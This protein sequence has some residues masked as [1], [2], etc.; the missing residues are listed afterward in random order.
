MSFEYKNRKLL[1]FSLLDITERKKAEE[2]LKESEAYNKVL[3]QDSKIPLIIMAPETAEFIDC[4]DAAV[5]IYGCKNREE[6]IGKTPVHFS[7]KMQDDGQTTEIKAKNNIKMAMEN[8]FVNFE[9]KHYR[10][11]GET[12]DAE[13]QLMRFAYKNQTLLQCS[14][15]DI[16]ERKKAENELKHLRNY[17][18]NIINSMPSVL[19]GI[20]PS[21]MVTQWNL[22]AEKKTGI[23]SAKAVG[24][25][26]DEV[27]PQMQGEM[28]RVLDAIRTREMKIDPKI[29]RKENGE[30]VYEDITIFP[31]I[32]NGIEGAVIRVDDVSERVRLEEMMI[33]SEK[34]MSVGGLAAGMAH[35]INNPLAGILQNLQVIK[36][37]LSA[38]L[39][40]N[41]EIAEKLKISIDT[42]IQY[43]EER[44]ILKMLESVTESGRRAAKIVENMLRFSRKSEA[45][46]NPQKIDILLDETIELARNDYDLK[47]KF[48]FRQIEIKKEIEANLP[49]VECEAS[50]I[51]QVFLNILKNGAQ[52]MFESKTQQMEQRS[53]EEPP[54]FY[55]RL[56]RNEKMLKIEIEDNGPGMPNEVRKRIFEPFFTTKGVGAGTGL[57]LSVSYF[58]IAE[59]HRGSIEVESEIGKGT[60]F[61]IQLP[62]S[63]DKSNEGLNR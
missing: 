7:P 12:W 6:F 41:I 48:D 54:I 58:I 56:N 50:E 33:Q 28:K 26:L 24:N 45:R 32:A 57:G 52:A 62:I 38:N 44:Q 25:P 34:M 22:E 23:T 51:Q 2:A 13:V 3:F 60:K 29:P 14:L 19:V 43:L 8:G 10:A 15:V 49:G 55:L 20:D 61:I 40:K 46:F 31:L 18:S 21:G 17:L 39:P 16:T 47:K 36:N 35:E 37:R 27:L 59:N 11:N 5:Q 9:W 63:R 4:N 30:I 42:I 1:Q 53:E